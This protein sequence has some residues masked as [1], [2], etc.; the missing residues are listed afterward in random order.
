MSSLGMAT[1]LFLAGVAEYA[2]IGGWYHSFNRGRVGE[3]VALTHVQ[4]LLWLFVVGSVVGVLQD[5]AGSKWYILAYIEGCALSA[6]GTAWY[7]ARQRKLQAARA[8]AVCREATAW[9]A[10]LEAMRSSLPRPESGGRSTGRTRPAQERAVPVAG[11][12]PRPARRRDGYNRVIAGR[13]AE[14]SSELASPLS[15]RDF[16]EEET[17]P[18]SRSIA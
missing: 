17:E 7:A 16:A 11:A 8:Q 10:R 13:S 15:R 14:E 3:V 9:R 4:L 12:L 1:A 2:I 6:G 5:P 18:P